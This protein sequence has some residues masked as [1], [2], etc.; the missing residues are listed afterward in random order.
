MN[1]TLSCTLDLDS[2]DTFIWLYICLRLFIPEALVFEVCGIKRIN[3][4]FDIG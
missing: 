3:L 2:N 4:V 1:S